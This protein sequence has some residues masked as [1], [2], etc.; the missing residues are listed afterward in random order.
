MVHT[1]SGHSMHNVVVF[2]CWEASVF[3]AAFGCSANL[4]PRICLP[5]LHQRRRVCT[6]HVISSCDRLGTGVHNWVVVEN[7]RGLDS[8][9]SQRDEVEMRRRIR[10]RLPTTHRLIREF[11][12]VA[13]QA[14]AGGRVA[15]VDVQV[16]VHNMGDAVG[17]LPINAVRSPTSALNIRQFVVNHAGSRAGQTLSILHCW[18]ETAQY[19]ILRP[20][21]EDGWSPA[22]QASGGSRR[23][24]LAR[25]CT[26]EVLR[27]T[28]LTSSC[29][30]FGEYLCDSA[31][32]LHDERLS[33]VQ[34]NRRRLVP[35]RELRAAV[36]ARG[37]GRGRGSGGRGGRWHGRRGGGRLGQRGRRRR[38][39]ESRVEGTSFDSLPGRTILPASFTTSQRWYQAYLEDA[40]AVGAR[41]GSPTWFCTMTACPS[42]PEIA[43]ELL[44]GQTASDRCVPRWGFL[45]LRTT[46]C[47]GCGVSARRFRFPFWVN[48]PSLFQ[49]SFHFFFYLLIMK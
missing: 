30:L 16:E 10:A 33:F 32:R 19:P 15:P 40:L 42:W 45:Q 44:P 4:R 22:M 36:S 31:S 25:F 28:Y 14:R 46:L 7:L 38:V 37:R 2:S 6:L 12:M 21:G 1:A 29:R 43:N 27:S 48:I 13:Q 8:T 23:I 5:H 39:V 17:V 47:L 18:Y 20:C 41:L 9:V 3:R 26:Q 11:R 34:H 49:I 35:F 24:T